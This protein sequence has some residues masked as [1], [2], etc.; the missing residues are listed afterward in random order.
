MINAHIIGWGKYLPEKIIT[1]EDLAKSAGVDAEWVRTRTG[2][3]ARHVAAP[4]QASVDMGY[5]AARAALNVADLAPSRLDLIIAATNTPDYTFPATACLIQDALGADNAGA[6]DLAAGCS[7]FLYALASAVQFIRTGAYRHILVI[8]VETASRI[9][10]W[11]DK[12]TCPYFG[13]GA[14]AVVLAASEQPGGMLA[15][16]LHSDGSG[17]DL[18]ILPGGG[19]RHPLSQETLDQGLH[20][21]RMDGRAVFR[22]GLRESVRNAHKVLRDAKMTID[23]VDLFIPHQTNI[24]LIQQIM[25]RLH[26]P[27]GKTM[28]NVAHTANLSSAALPVTLCDAIEQNR[29]KPGARILFTAYG[30]GLASAGVLW[31]WSKEMPQKRM[32]FLKRLGHALWDAQAA[33]RSRLFQLE[34]RVD[35]LIAEEEE[36][37][38]R[39]E[40]QNSKV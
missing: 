9:L 13:D 37:P 15:F 8:G 14:G 17:G 5:R 36:L 7:A 27:L 2:I 28:I 3:E 18:L 26:V 6:H 25:E 12:N 32:P 11:S 30:G 35:A 33:F 24:T 19:S 4:K 31:Q 23:D 40:N 16:T 20:R 1:N 39:E 34:H 22:Y 29:V 21:G 10:D 38:R